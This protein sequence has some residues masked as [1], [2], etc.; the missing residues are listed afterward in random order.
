MSL[1]PVRATAQAQTD[2]LSTALITRARD[3]PAI[4][5][6]PVDD[7]RR[8]ATVGTGIFFVLGGCRAEGRAGRAHPF[9]IAASRPA[10]GPVLCRTRL[11]HPGSAGRPI[12]T[13]ITRSGSSS[14]SSSPAACCSN[15][16][17]RRSGRRRLERLLQR[18][19]SRDHRLAPA[20]RALGLTDPRYGRRGD[21]WLRSISPPGRPGPVHPAH[22]RPQSRPDQRDPWCMDQTPPP[23]SCCSR[24]SAS[25]AFSNA[26]HFSNFFAGLHRRERRSRYRKIGLDAVA[27]PARKSDPQRRLP[28]R[29]S[30]LTIVSG[31]YLAVAAAGLRRW[32][33]SF[34]ENSRQRRAGLALILQREITGTEIWGDPPPGAVISIFSVTLVASL[35]PGPASSS[36]GSAATG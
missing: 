16:A 35:W 18:T 36:R 7:V 1:P 4:D 25:A 30:A 11:R 28:G 17:S 8:R 29:S 23:S 15:T 13:P 12:P 3:S 2:R 21:R 27:C 33:V 31:V 22:P 19:V 34:F 5:D 10:V 26:D 32:P 14:P 20:E 24:S 6:L 9:M